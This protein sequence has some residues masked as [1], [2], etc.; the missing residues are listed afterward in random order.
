MS[1]CSL[2]F[3]SHYI[4]VMGL[5]EVVRQLRSEIRS[6]QLLLQWKAQ[7]ARARLLFQASMGQVVL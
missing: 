2:V 3:A 5:S 6:Q 4:I 7:M 1:K